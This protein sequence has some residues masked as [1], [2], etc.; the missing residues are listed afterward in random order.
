MMIGVNS[1]SCINSDIAKD[2]PSYTDET[3]NLLK[4]LNRKLK[5][6]TDFRFHDT[7]T[8]SIIFTK[9]HQKLLY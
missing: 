1:K 8:K 3:L 7:I 5:Q 4:N 9:S 6:N 2:N